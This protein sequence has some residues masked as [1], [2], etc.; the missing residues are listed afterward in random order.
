[1]GEARAL[2]PVSSVEACANSTVLQGLLLG[3]VALALITFGVGDIVTVA[4]AI[5]SVLAVLMGRRCAG[6]QVQRHLEGLASD[7]DLCTGT[8]D[9]APMTCGAGDMRTC[10]T[11]NGTETRRVDCSG[12]YRCNRPPVT[13]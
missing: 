12:P 6:R 5:A 1:M 10:R 11:I 8:I 7:R 2:H 9:V 3:I 13:L 4:L